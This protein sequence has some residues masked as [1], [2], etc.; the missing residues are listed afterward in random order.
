M[1]QI[2]SGYSMDLKR[3]K[4]LPNAEDDSIDNQLH[5][6]VKIVS[7]QPEESHE[8]SNDDQYLR[9]FCDSL[10]SD[11]KCISDRKNLLK[12]KIEIMQI[13]DKYSNEVN[14]S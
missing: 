3:P 14:T 10:V 13:I 12:C 1:D 6:F 2:G 5:E 8:S 4:F 7:K 9:N 11:L